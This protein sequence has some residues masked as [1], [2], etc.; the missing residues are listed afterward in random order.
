[1]IFNTFLFKRVCGELV[2]KTRILRTFGYHFCKHIV[3][4]QNITILYNKIVG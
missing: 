3:Y 2:T 1:M 4:M